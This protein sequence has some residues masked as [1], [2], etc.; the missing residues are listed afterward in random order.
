MATPPYGRRGTKARSKKKTRTP[1]TPSASA[2]EHASPRA[3]FK[4]AG[5]MTP[6]GQRKKA[7]RTGP[8]PAPASG[9]SKSPSR[10]GSSGSVRNGMFGSVKPIAGAS[11]SPSRGGDRFTSHVGTPATKRVGPKPGTGNSGA[12]TA[13]KSPRPVAGAKGP[14]PSAQA[15]AHASPNA[16]F[17]RTAPAPGG[18]RVPK[19]AKSPVHTPPG[20][21]KKVGRVGKSLSQGKG[22]GSVGMP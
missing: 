1:G 9:A 12:D 4:R 2:F 14:H 7:A 18:V 19:Q 6:P 17:K 15:I 8:K 11:K 10:T 13:P 5:D 21:S 22:R 16:R 3:R 20:L